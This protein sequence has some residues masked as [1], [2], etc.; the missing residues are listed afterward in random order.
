M[1]RKRF[2]I[3]LAETAGFCMGV[4]RAVKMT[5]RA[6]DEP[7]CPTPIRT[8]GPLI[9]NRQV[10]QVLESRGIISA[11]DGD[12]TEGGTCVIRAHGLPRDEQEAL[13]RRSEALLDA[14]CPHVRRV[15]EIVADYARRGYACVVVGDAGHAEVNGV[16]SHADGA[17][18]VVSGPDEVRDLPPASRVVVVAQTTQDEQVFRRTVAKVRERFGECLAFETICRSTERRQAEVR[19]LAPKV[20]AMIVVGGLD[21]ANTRRLAEISSAVGTPTY[22]VETDRELDVDR[23]LG[24]E[25]VGLTAGASTPNWMIRKVVRRLEDE[26]RR[27][28]GLGPYLGRMAVRGLVNANIYAA[29]GAAALTFACSRLLQGPPA[30]LGVCMAVT[31]FFVLSQQLLNQYGRREALYLSDPDRADFFMVNERGLL[32]L[33]VTSALVAPIL[34]SFLGWWAFLLVVVGSAGGLMYRFRLPPALSRKTGFRSLEH[35]PASKE[36]FV[37][38]A[39]GV[40]ASAVPALAAGPGPHALRDGFVAFTV[41]FLMAFART[42][43]LDLRDVEAD[44]IVGR[45]TLAG[46]VGALAAKRVFFVVVGVLAAVLVLAGHLQG[47]A[48][49]GWAALLLGVPYAVGSFGLLWWRGRGP[50]GELAEAMVDGQFYLV[51]LAALVLGSMSGKA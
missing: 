44:Q 8:C 32:L 22:H 11:E 5:L 47:W 39:W 16:L 30:L 45:E 41:A 43:A 40:L 50:T 31:F 14:T 46:V 6:A 21:S 24:Y 19:E 48:G 49:P 29:G 51:G 7:D 38:L 9:H 23:I 34:A 13:R 42:V 10:L 17:G 37:G 27:R 36:V 12:A 15:Q 26:D 18:Y 33:G 25:T 20:D 2:E 1:A 3:V 28:A 35:L 4:R